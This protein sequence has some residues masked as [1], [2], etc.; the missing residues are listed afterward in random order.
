MKRRRHFVFANNRPS[1]HACPEIFRHD[2]AFET[3][4]ATGAQDRVAQASLHV[5]S[6]ASLAAA[7]PANLGCCW[8]RRS[9]SKNRHT[10]H[11][12]QRIPDVRRKCA[13][14][15]E[16]GRERLTLSLHISSQISGVAADE[17]DARCTRRRR[18]R[19]PAICPSPSHTPRYGVHDI[20][21]GLGTLRRLVTHDP[22][23]SR[24]TSRT[25]SARVACA[26]LCP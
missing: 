26:Y 16:R 19:G 3:R 5:S 1:L 21:P 17:Y 2:S 22:G 12:A 13:L 4:V 14:Y 20:I 11:L 7:P 6:K 8:P 18:C 10:D 15:C 23:L 9:G 24:W 25:T